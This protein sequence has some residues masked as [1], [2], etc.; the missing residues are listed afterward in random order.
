MSR[1]LKKGG[2]LLAQYYNELPEDISKLRQYCIVRRRCCLS[3]SLLM[4]R[5]CS[6]AMRRCAD[7]SRLLAHS[8][9]RWHL[10]Q[11]LE[12]SFD[13]C[14]PSSAYRHTQCIGVQWRSVWC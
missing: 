14:V 7:M 3:T 11:A 2:K 5:I 9:S 12:S 6:A 1:K 8:G 13:L 10:H 4:L